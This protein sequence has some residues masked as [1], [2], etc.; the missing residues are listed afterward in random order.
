MY[1]VLSLTALCFTSVSWRHSACKRL[2]QLLPS[3]FSLLRPIKLSERDK[4]TAPKIDWE[5]EDKF[6]SSDSIPAASNITLLKT[7][8]NLEHVNQD[9]LT[10]VKDLPPNKR[11][12]AFKNLKEKLME[13]NPNS[14]HLWNKVVDTGLVVSKKLRMYLCDKFDQTYYQEFRPLQFERFITFPDS[15][16]QGHPSPDI[17]DRVNV[18]GNSG[19]GLIEL[20]F[21]DMFG[22]EDNEDAV[23]NAVEPSVL[24]PHDQII[25]MSTLQRAKVFD[26]YGDQHFVDNHKG[27]SPSTSK[28]QGFNPLLPA[29][30]QL[31]NLGPLTE[32]ES[33]APTTVLNATCPL[34]P[35]KTRVP[36][37][38][39]VKYGGLHPCYLLCTH[40]A[41]NTG[42]IFATAAFYVGAQQVVSL[43]APA[44]E[45][46]A[47]KSLLKMMNDSLLQIHAAI[48]APQV[49]IANVNG[50]WSTAN[51]KANTKDSKDS[52]CC[53]HLLVETEGSTGI[54]S[55]G[56]KA[57][58]KATTAVP[59]FSLPKVVPPRPKK[60]LID[61]NTLL[62]FAASSRTAEIN[63]TAENVMVTQKDAFRSKWNASIVSLQACDFLSF[64]RMAERNIFIGNSR[65]A[66]HSYYSLYLDMIVR[67]SLLLYVRTA[68]ADGMCPLDPHS[69]DTQATTVS[70]AGGED[71]LMADIRVAV[72][73]FRTKSFEK[74]TLW[75]RGFDEI[76]SLQKR[77]DHEDGKALFPVHSILNQGNLSPWRALFQGVRQTT[78]V[79]NF[80]NSDH[81]KLLQQQNSPRN[82]NIV[83]LVDPLPTT[84][85]NYHRLVIGLAKEQIIV[86]TDDDGLEL[87]KHMRA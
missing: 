80:Q 25:S 16:A 5:A 27:S 84:D 2:L 17:A 66:Q 74:V 40:H 21:G 85:A 56:T 82:F 33:S 79:I 53:L 39:V 11:T 64:E 51:I 24:I 42:N 78:I 58:E 52:S 83:I 1:D 77:N 32:C 38:P 49:S 72:V 20:N 63:K 31:M 13:K 36:N 18:N 67:P 41:D 23:S 65:E 44:T 86:M 68:T 59:V 87:K 6:I 48:F 4:C 55:K 8:S 50:N 35:M 57:T 76:L 37:A 34:L 45:K 60:T 12:E 29:P 19:K 62:K 28:G 7:E 9:A 54:K 46:S 3:T 30:Q 69:A 73:C 61:H 71:K 10:N 43:T 47:S 75:K 26:I 14:E 15:D 81:T 22:F 70:H